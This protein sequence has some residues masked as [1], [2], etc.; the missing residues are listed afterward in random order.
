MCSLFCMFSELI[1]D[2]PKL[3]QFG[4]WAGAQYCFTTK[5][6]L[7]MRAKPVAELV[8][9]LCS[10]EHCSAP[11]SSPSSAENKMGSTASPMRL[12]TTDIQGQIKHVSKE[13]A[14]LHVFRAGFPAAKLDVFPSTNIHCLLWNEDSNLKKNI[15]INVGMVC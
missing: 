6:F 4:V 1:G 11:S 12:H 5:S 9:Q 14:L 3:L 8:P 15:Y 10:L 2:V 7:C 13:Q